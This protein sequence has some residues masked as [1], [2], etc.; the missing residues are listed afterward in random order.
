MWGG[1]VGGGGVG[2]A[3]WGAAR[4][5]SRGG[6]AGRPVGRSRPGGAEP[7][8]ASRR[9]LRR[10]RIYAGADVGHW[11]RGFDH[12]ALPLA[13]IVSTTDASEASGGW[14]G[15]DGGGGG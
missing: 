7:P 1:D 9:A 13:L 8:R 10:C 4:S 6:G 3:V 5:S 2:A 15:W 14:G 12:A 11:P